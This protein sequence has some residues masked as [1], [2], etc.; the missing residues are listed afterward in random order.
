[1]P[2]VAASNHH[3]ISFKTEI[4]AD[5]RATISFLLWKQKEL[6]LSEINLSNEISG[7]IHSPKNMAEEIIHYY[8]CI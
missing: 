5:K 6:Y 3:N 8:L 1:M 7:R 4:S 2:N